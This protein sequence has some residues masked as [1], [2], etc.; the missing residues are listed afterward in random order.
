MRSISV[1]SSQ[2]LHSVQV[3]LKPE[4]DKSRDVDLP[5]ELT[6][7]VR[8]SIGPF[9]APKQV[10]SCRISLPRHAAEISLQ[11]IVI[12]DLPKTRSGKVRQDLPSRCL[13]LSPID[14]A[15]HMPQSLRWR[16]RPAR[17]SQ[18]VLTAPFARSRCSWVKPCTGTLAD[19]SIVD[20]IKSASSS[21]GFPMHHRASHLQRRSPLTRRTRRS[22]REPILCVSPLIWLST[23]T[24]RTLYTAALV[25]LF[26]N[27]QSVEALRALSRTPL[28]L[29]NSYK[30]AKSR[31]SGRGKVV[32]GLWEDY[33]LGAIRR[34]AYRL[35]CYRQPRPLRTSVT[36]SPA[37]LQHR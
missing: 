12:S 29:C 11:I 3:T 9:A 7:Q 20:E 4:V 2:L 34:R 22:R 18:C 10:L 27:V 8:R 15:T 28:D 5:K 16:R 32:T 25:F 19:P 17:R 23:S 30:W 14:H 13:I 35:R 33:E 6:L 1:H 21:S 26:C 36:L 24:S 31:S 37:V